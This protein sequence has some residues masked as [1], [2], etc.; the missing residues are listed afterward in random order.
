MGKRAWLNDAIATE[1]LPF[2]ASL[3]DNEKGQAQAEQFNQT[4]RKSW[5]A[6]GLTKLSQQQSLMDTTRK[7]IKNYQERKAL[8]FELHQIQHFGIYHLKRC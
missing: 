2:L 7:A 3:D 1:Y 4:I 5:S 6:R 8:Q